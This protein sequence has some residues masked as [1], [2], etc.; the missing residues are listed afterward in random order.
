MNKSLR[1][2]SSYICQKC[3]TEIL[4]QNPP[5]LLHYALTAFLEYISVH[6]YIVHT[7][8]LTSVLVNQSHK[9]FIY[10]QKT[11]WKHYK[12]RQVQVQVYS[13]RAYGYANDHL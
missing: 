9:T 1:Q 7:S 3:T 8:R 6:M 12:Y 11:L 13:L 10:D 4:L 5:D 2:S